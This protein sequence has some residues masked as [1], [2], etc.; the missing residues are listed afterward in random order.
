MWEYQTKE[1]DCWIC[2]II[3]A[4]RFKKH[5]ISKERILKIISSYGLETNSDA[6]FFTYIPLILA[7]H[8]YKSNLYLPPDKAFQDIIRNNKVDLKLI[9]KKIYILLKQRDAMLFLYLALKYCVQIGVKVKISPINVKYFLMEG[10]IVIAGVDV[11]KY[12]GIRDDLSKHVV[13]LM[14]YDDNFL[15]VDPLERIG[16][17]LIPDWEIFMD[18]SRKYNWEWAKCYAA[19]F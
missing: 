17:N 2:S 4:L 10:K 16:E 5:D 13:S 19:V 9:E 18:N 14:P 15:C 1:N 6:G 8:G 7:A 12:Y 3:N 11:E